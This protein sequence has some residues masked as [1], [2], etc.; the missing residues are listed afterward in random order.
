[1]RGEGWRGKYVGGEGRRGKYVR[2]EGWRVMSLY[3]PLGGGSA[4]S[5]G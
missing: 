2:G 5:G 4:S 3:I 1:M